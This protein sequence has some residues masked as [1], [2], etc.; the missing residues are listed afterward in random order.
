MSSLAGGVAGHDVNNGAGAAR[1]LL[2]GDVV[3]DV[4]RL[5][6]EDA[7]AWC[8][9]DGVERHVPRH[10]GVFDQRDLRWVSVQQAGDRGVDCFS[11]VI[12]RGSGFVAANVGFKPQML[13]LR[14]QHWCRHQC[15]AGIVEMQDLVRGGRVAACAL[16]VDG[17]ERLRSVLAA[18]RCRRRC[19]GRV[20]GVKRD[21]I[22]KP[23]GSRFDMWIAV[24]N[25]L[26][27]GGMINAMPHWRASPPFLITSTMMA[28]KM[29]FP[30]HPRRSRCLN[31]NASIGAA[32]H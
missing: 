24:P 6:G 2:E 28:T 20:V 3:A 5:G 29:P 14:V 27:Q 25:S 7:I 32:R 22:G 11:T 13:K 15:S 17:H 18:I 30:L 1:D 21:P 31:P 8:E 26:T 12:G 10:S 16:D 19:G 23:P 9:G 4:L